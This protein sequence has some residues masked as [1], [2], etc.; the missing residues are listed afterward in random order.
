MGR[1]SLPEEGNFLACSPGRPRWSLILTPLMAPPKRRWISLGR[2]LG[3]AEPCPPVFRQ[4]NGV[5]ISHA[6][7][8]ATVDDGALASGSGSRMRGPHRSRPP[9][10]EEGATRARLDAADCMFAQDHGAW[11]VAA[12]DSNQRWSRDATQAGRVVFQIVYNGVRLDLEMS[13]WPAPNRKFM[14]TA[15]SR[16]DLVD[17]VFGPI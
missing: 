17:S 10:L 7:T 1:C 8:A 14:V 13:K 16:K 9:G 15:G 4:G 11:P 12:P 2:Q 6:C 5:Q 3:A